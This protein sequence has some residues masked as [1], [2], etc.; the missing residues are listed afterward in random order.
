M[1]WPKMKSRFEKSESF[2]V[3]ADREQAE[4]WRAAAHLQALGSVSEWLAQ[5]ADFYLSEISKTGKALP[6]GWSGGWF[7]V[8]IQPDGRVEAVGIEVKGRTYP[9][10]GIFRGSYRGSKAAGSDASF[11]LVHLPTCRIL[12]TLPRQKDCAMLAAELMP[13]QINWTEVDPEKVIQGTPDQSRLQEI[14]R[15]YGLASSG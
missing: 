2:A 1:G 13:L 7:R 14:V 10:F 8:L 9:P 11:S 3:P 15:L 6:L 5:T 4:R 12:C